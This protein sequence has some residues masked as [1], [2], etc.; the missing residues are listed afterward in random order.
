MYLFYRALPVSNLWFLHE[1]PAKTQ[2][3]LWMPTGGWVP[4]TYLPPT[5]ACVSSSLLHHQDPSPPSQWYVSCTGQLSETQQSLPSQWAYGL[6]LVFP[7]VPCIGSDFGPTTAWLS[8]TCFTFATV[9]VCCP[10]PSSRVIFLSAPPCSLASSFLALP[11]HFMK[12]CSGPI[13]CIY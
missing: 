10:Q 4:W 11:L 8:A 2:S 7:G 13:V 5:S 3:S 6:M 12:W 1:N 9:P